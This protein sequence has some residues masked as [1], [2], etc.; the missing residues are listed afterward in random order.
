MDA[1]IGLIKKEIQL[2][3]Y[4][5]LIALGV[6]LVNFLSVSFF[7]FRNHVSG[8]ILTWVINLLV[9]HMFYLVLYIAFSLGMEGKGGLLW[10]SHP[11]PGWKRLSAKYVA[12]VFSF[13]VSLLFTV[14]LGIISSL[15]VPQY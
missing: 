6:V 1:W 8:F 13:T 3:R 9:A 14:L 11:H 10:Q 15:M 7:S 12:G 4:F 5:S 2:M